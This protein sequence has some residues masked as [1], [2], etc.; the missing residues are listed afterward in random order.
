VSPPEL[1]I[2]LWRV[3]SELMD[4][5]ILDDGGCLESSPEFNIGQCWVSGE[6]TDS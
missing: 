4:S 3:L 2:G 5:S 1:S 6:L